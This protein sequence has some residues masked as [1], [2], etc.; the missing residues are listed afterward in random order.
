[1]EFVLDG[2]LPAPWDEFWLN[3]RRLRGS[4]FLMRWSQ[5]AW[6]EKSLVRAVDETGGYFALPYGPSSTAPEDNVREFEKYFEQLEDAGLADMKRPDL[7]VF[8]SEDRDEMMEAVNRIGGV[9]RLP[10]TPEKHS[11]MCLLISRA[12][13][14]VECENSLWRATK[15][16]DYRAELKPMKRLGG[17]LGLKK[18]AVLPTIIIKEE[19]R[20]RLW[21]WQ[22]KN[23]LPIH[24]WH[25]FFDAA[26][27]LA[28]ADA[29]KLIDKK[30][31]LGTEQIFQAPSGATTKKIIYKIYHQSIVSHFL[32]TRPG[33]QY[34]ADG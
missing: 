25:V 31:I 33:I 23:H 11:D 2:H 18:N 26:F 13:L 6:S 4:D 10:F 17:K 12:L 20:P 28:L 1:M 7:L 8:R 21:D 16:P 22:R 9:P 34:L 24:I 30:L 5:G 14:A 3:P 32:E 29:Q 19:D 27:G 15:M